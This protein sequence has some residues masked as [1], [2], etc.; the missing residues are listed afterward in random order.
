MVAGML[1]ITSVEKVSLTTYSSTAL[2]AESLIVSYHYS[3]TWKIRSTDLQTKAM[4]ERHSTENMATL[5]QEEQLNSLVF[6]FG[7]RCLCVVCWG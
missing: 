2:T 7:V 1:N 6:V 3:S 5:R 4:L